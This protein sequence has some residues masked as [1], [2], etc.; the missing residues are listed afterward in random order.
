MDAGKTLCFATVA[1]AFTSSGLVAGEVHY[2][3]TDPNGNVLAKADA[4]GDIVAR[5]DYKP[6]GSSVPS[7]GA[8]PDGPGYSGHVNDP[9][10]GL[11]YM[12]A[13]Y[14]DPGSARFLSVDPDD[15]GLGN[16]F[17]YN[18]HEYVNNNPVM[19][20]DPTGRV[21]QIVGDTNFKQRM[22]ADIRTIRQGPG[23]HVL[24]EKLQAT[25]NIIYVEPQ[26]PGQGQQHP[27]R[28][29]RHFH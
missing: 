28:S 25:P 1:L 24:I 19:G 23:G 29:F 5:Y 16:V 27:G 21:I 4:Q 10:T 6:Y 13:R 11:I 8:P 12:Q 7:T 26:V 14:Y 9:D 15:P 20:V 3:Y 22:Q 17:N 18:R 2:Y